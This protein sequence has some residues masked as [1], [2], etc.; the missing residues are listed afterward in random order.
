MGSIDAD[1]HVIE[2]PHTFSYMDSSQKNFVPMVVNQIAGPEKKSREGNVRKEYWVVD[3]RIF[4]KDSNVGSNTSPESRE[5]SDIGARLKHMDALEI[6]IQV[7][8]PTLF[9]RPVTENRRIEYALFRSYNRW[10]ADIWKRGKERLRWV[11][12]APF[13][14]L[15]LA[16]E[17]L[18]FC[19]EHGACGIFMR[20]PEYHMRAS[21]PYF[22]PLYEIAAELD[23]AICHHSGNGATEVHDF[24][25]ETAS[26]PR[27]KLAVVG[28]FHD[29]LMN[30][31]PR[32]FP[33]VRWGFVE[34]SGQWLPYALKDAAIRLKGMGRRMPADPLKEY[35]MY[36]AL[37]VTDDFDHIFQ[38]V[39]SDNLVVG[40]DYGHHDTASE[41]EALRL[42]KTQGR[43]KADVADKILEANARTLYGL[44]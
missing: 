32:Q 10:L 44:N 13:R 25:D 30:D 22:F 34:V 37:Q 14:S 15:D 11:A 8:Y 6:D 35:N 43:M 3:N 4:A 26:F 21:D 36:V 9:L 23:M 5:M 28:A 39:G 42:I 17:E 18:I 40:T 16:R 27:F 19:K 7:L 29:L 1:A 41:I 12:M 33:K 38:Y 31:I 20:G 2:T 24:F